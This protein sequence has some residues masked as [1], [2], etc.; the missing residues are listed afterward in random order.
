MRIRSTEKAISRPVYEALDERGLPHV[1]EA[2]VVGELPT[3]EQRRAA[4]LE[5]ASEIALIVGIPQICEVKFGSLVFRAF[6][7]MSYRQARAHAS[8]EILLVRG[9]DVPLYFCPSFTPSKS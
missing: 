7:G 9:D 8:A 4:L 5:S 6:S 2:K 3:P 1:R